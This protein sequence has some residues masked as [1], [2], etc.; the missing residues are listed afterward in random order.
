M[1]KVLLTIA[2]M[3]SGG[4]EHQLS[5]LANYL[6]QKGYDVCIKTF[7]DIPDHY[8][9][10]EKIKRKRIAPNRHKVIKILGL[11][12]S[13]LLTKYDVVIGFGARESALV[14]IP[15]LFRPRIIFIAG[16]RCALMKNEMNWYHKVNYNFL[17]KRANYIVPNSYTQRD[18]IIKRD[19]SYAKK[20]VV[21]TN[22][23]DC[24][25]Y[26]VK[27][28]S[29]H[30]G[31]KIG[32][33]GRYS[34]QK[35]CLRFA[36]AIQLLSTRTPISFHIDWYGNIKDKTNTI[37]SQFK[38]LIEELNI[39]NFIEL[40]DHVK[41]V[42]EVIPLFDVMCLPSLTEGFS[43]SISEYICCGKPVICSDVAD[44]KIM[45][46]NG[47]NGFLFNPYDEKDICQSFLN[48]FALS[49][50]SMEKMGKE[51]RAIAEGLF[52]LEGFG[53]SYINLIES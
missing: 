52:D 2:S 21:I 42:S 32:V 20:T 34:E 29:K 39:G 6:V 37:Y 28:L 46:K 30:D 22:F 38:N 36:K 47:V 24:G 27:R 16:E 35:N 13:I 25:K 26:V 43:N 40:H 3:S 45:V 23:T 9:L 31:I 1:K 50:E 33:L 18:D 14:G 41:D 17:F 7:V 4:A 19:A 53:S 11:L 48:F 49:S 5:I 44:N 12:K 8:I 10:D 15:L 51:S